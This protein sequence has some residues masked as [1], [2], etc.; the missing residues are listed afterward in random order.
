M[1]LAQAQDA[2]EHWRSVYNHER[3]HEALGMQTPAARYQVSPRALPAALAPIEYGPND[4]V[5]VGRNGWVYFE[6][7]KLRLS[8]A[9]HRLPVAMRPDP[10][11]DG[12]FDTFFCH[13][14]FMRLDLRNPA[15][16][17]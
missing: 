16:P 2:F 4:R 7:R 12:C 5:L 3:P 10:K 17:S 13:H 1:D 14:R 9:L 11:A 15:T 8:S 6:G